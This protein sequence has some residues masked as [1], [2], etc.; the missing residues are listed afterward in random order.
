[1]LLCSAPF[2][3]QTSSGASVHAQGVSLLEM[4]LVIAL[5]ALIS[6]LGVAVLS[7]GM[8]GVQLRN[9]GKQLAAELRY[10]RTVAL[11]TGTAQRFMIDPQRRRWQGPNGH[12]GKLP[13]A[14]QIRFS[15]AQQLQTSSGEGVIQFYDDGA[16][17]GGRIDLEMKRAYWRIDVGWITGEVRSGP[18]RT[19][20]SL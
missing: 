2:R 14:L 19:A 1:M 5:I 10:T 9:S 13:G 11:A 6:L 7:G 17:S 15:G 18:L 3:F 8:D 12:Q 4:L 20:A 16:S